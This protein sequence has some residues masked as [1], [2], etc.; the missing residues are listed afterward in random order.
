VIPLADDPA[1]EDLTIDLYAGPD[2]APSAVRL[3]DGTAIA[4]T[5]GNDGAGRLDVTGPD[6]GYAL[7]LPFQP[8]LGVVGATAVVA[9]R[10]DAWTWRGAAT[11]EIGQRR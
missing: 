8:G 6:R 9:A 7:R 3:P 5:P 11:V 2:A 10:D 1:S 4:F